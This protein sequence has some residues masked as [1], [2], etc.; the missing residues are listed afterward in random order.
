MTSFLQWQT[1]GEPNTPYQIL[2]LVTQ[3]GTCLGSQQSCPGASIIRLLHEGFGPSGTQ[4]FNTML[5]IKPRGP[6]TPPPPEKGTTA[7]YSMIG[8][9]NACQDA[10]PPRLTMQTIGR[11]RE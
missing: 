2:L 11:C 10:L 1:T 9:G 8:W 6:R 4:I 5:N 7:H 3:L